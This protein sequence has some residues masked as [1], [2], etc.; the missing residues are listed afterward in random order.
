MV[1][2]NMGENFTLHTQLDAPL[3]IWVKDF[4][5]NGSIDKILT[6]TIDEKD[7]PVFLEKRNGKQFPA[8]KKQILQHAEYAKKSCKICSHRMS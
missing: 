6:K 7:S 8:L 4:D 2:G 1:L 5:K 3:K